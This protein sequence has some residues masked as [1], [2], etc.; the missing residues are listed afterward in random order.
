MSVNVKQ[1]SQACDPMAVEIFVIIRKKI[2][3]VCAAE[4]K[5]ESRSKYK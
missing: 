3:D 4:G 5:L 1:K 2:Q